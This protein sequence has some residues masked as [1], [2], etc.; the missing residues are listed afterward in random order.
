MITNG[1]LLPHYLVNLIWWIRKIL[2]RFLSSITWIGMLFHTM[3]SED[4]TLV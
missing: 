2:G 4:M 1:I 3:T